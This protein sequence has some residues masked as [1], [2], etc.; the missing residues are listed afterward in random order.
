MLEVSLKVTKKQKPIVNTQKKIKWKKYKHTTIE[1]HETTRAR[2][3]E[4]REDYKN[5]QKITNDNKYILI[6]NYYKYNGLNFPI[7]NDLE[8]LNE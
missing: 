4:Q 8:W 3:K 7:K 1:S 2:R 5:S 6:N